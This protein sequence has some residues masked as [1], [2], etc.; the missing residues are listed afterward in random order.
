MF[1]KILT[2][3]IRR[4]RNDSECRGR[5][6][7]HPRIRGIRQDHG[8]S[9]ESISLCLQCFI[10]SLDH[11]PWSEWYWIIDPDTGQFKETHLQV[12][13]LGWPGLRSMIQD[14]S[15]HGASKKPSKSTMA[16][17]YHFLC[18]TMNRGILDHSFWLV[19][20]QRNASLDRTFIA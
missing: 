8:K 20:S 14:Y 6:K 3:I 2:N 5:D 4:S 18:C 9:K 13:F 16:R 19:S 7:A 1:K 17:I 15:D 11:A 10:G 12:R